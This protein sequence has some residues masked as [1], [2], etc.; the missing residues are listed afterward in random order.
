ALHCNGQLAEMREVAAAASA[1]GTDASRRAAGALGRARHRP[2]PLDPVDAH[3]R[4]A[5]ALAAVS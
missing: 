2:E 5:A 4:F 3:A 1:L